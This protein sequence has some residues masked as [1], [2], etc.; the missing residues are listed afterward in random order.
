MIA[1]IKGEREKRRK[2]G[3]VRKERERREKRRAAPGEGEY[4][5]RGTYASKV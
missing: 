1:F 2:Q 4:H 3:K 5:G